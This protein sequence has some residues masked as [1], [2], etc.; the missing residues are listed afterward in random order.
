MI[1]PNRSQSAKYDHNWIHVFSGLIRKKNPC[2]NDFIEVCISDDQNVSIDGKQVWTFNSLCPV[3]S[4]R[5]QKGTTKIQDLATKGEAPFSYLVRS[6]VVDQPASKTFNRKMP[7]GGRKTLV[8]SDGRQ[9]AARLARDIPRNVEKDVF[10]I[11]LVLAADY[12]EKNHHSASLKKELIYLAFLNVIKDKNILLFDGDDRERLMSDLSKVDEYISDDESF[13]IMSE[14]TWTPTPQFLQM[15]LVNLFSPYYSLSALTIGSIYPAKRI[16]KKLEELKAKFLFSSEVV[17]LEIAVNWLTKIVETQFAFDKD[18]SHGIRRSATGYDGSDSD[19]GV[20]LGNNKSFFAR[21]TFL[22]KSKHAELEKDLLAMFCDESSG[23]YYVNPSKV[24]IRLNLDDVWFQCTSCT[25]LSILLI[26]NMCPHCGARDV[27]RLDPNQ[28]EYLRARKGFYRDPV[29]NALKVGSQFY[30]LCVEEHTAQLSYRDDSD[31]VSTNESYERRFKDILVEKNDY[32]VDILSCTTTMEVGVDI[33]SL[34]AVSMRNVPPAR[35]NYQ[36]RAGR[37]GRRGAA[38]STVLTFAQTGSHDSYFFENPDKIISGNP[39]VPEIDITNEKVIKRHVIAAI[40]QSYFHRMKIDKNNKNNDLLSV[41]GL[42]KDFYIG[43]DADFTISSLISWLN[44]SFQTSGVKAEISKWIPSN[45]NKL[46]IDNIKDYLIQELISAKP[47]NLEK[48]DSYEEKF[49][50]FLFGLGLLPSY[51][52]PRHVCAFNIEKMEGKFNIKIVE[53]PQQN[54]STAL[55]EYAPGRLVVVNKKTYKI[56][57]ITARSANTEENR[58]VALFDKKRRYLQCSNCLFTEDFSDDSLNRNSC[59]HCGK[60]GIEVLDVIQPEVV[61]PSGRSSINEFEDDDIYTSASSAQLPFMRD[62]QPSWENFKKTANVAFEENQTLVAINKGDDSSS[63]KSG[64]W[65]CSL[66][67]KATAEKDKPEMY[68]ERDYFVKGKSE[69]NKCSGEIVKVNIGYTFNSDVFILRLPLSYPMQQDNTNIE[70]EG[71]ITS[72]R[73]LS[74]A[75]LQETS[76]YLEIDPTELNC[77]IRFLKINEINY[78]DIFLYDTASGGAGYASMAG[79]YFSSIFSNTIKRLKKNDCCDSSC[80]RCLQNYGNRWHHNYLNKKYGL[81]LWR[82]IND[83]SLPFLYSS[84]EQLSIASSLNKLM[85][86]EGWSMSI[87]GT[88]SLIVKKDGKQ[89]KFL[90]YPVF[91]DVNYVKNEVGKTVVCCISD[92]EI[93]KSLPSAYSK[94]ISI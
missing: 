70:K 41:L 78:L 77:G 34:I 66:C 62:S 13:L 56:G 22:D 48:E 26:D 11:C 74:E 45:F 80:Y 33:G 55:T 49:L 57:S 24:R 75:I 76:G 29:I 64:F 37:A 59:T 68:H 90:I 72:A 52:F 65:V 89:I 92:Y 38:I 14:D 2:S 27:K 28:S 40:I 31:F 44:S 5:W 86:L 61:Y 35:Q 21:L 32:P 51:A 39:I 19:F 4:R 42:T 47:N 20:I 93:E 30:N 9:K 67:G 8:F 94:V 88:K 43:S 16:S 53:S 58:A 81:M 15:L 71:L 12:L 46:T 1:E 82:K 63:E 60:D 25:K 7:L 84:V 18:I 3:C 73:T 85:A 17:A 50:N 79:K 10:R 87:D 6:Q 83:D 23:K 91:L 36:Q 54:L 69:K